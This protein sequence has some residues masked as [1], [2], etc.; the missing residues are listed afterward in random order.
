[1]TSL[2]RW[3]RAAAPSG[4]AVARRRPEIVALSAEMPGID[5]L[6][7]FMRDAELRFE[8]LWM[9]IEERTFG[10]QGEQLTVSETA[11]RHPRLARVTTSEPAAGATG[12]FETWISDGESVRTYSRQHK[13][14]TER[15]V[16]PSVRGLDD[17]D[18]PG[19][20]KI[21][22]PLTALPMETLPETFIH[23]AGY[24]QN[25]LTT[26]RTWISGTEVVRGRETI[27]VQCD[28]PRAT[29][30]AADRP[31]FHIEIAVDRADGAILRLVE[32]IGGDVTRQA[33]AVA[34]EPDAALPPATF[35]FHFPAGTTMLY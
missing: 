17:P 33:V 22:R 5:E 13:L 12:S 1:M 9:R 30:L 8:S 27:V 31:D 28:H 3:D 19:H 10:T 24:C 6:F 32:T 20:T 23:P 29:E 15:P 2:Q 21:Y 26:G 18:L 11:L 16:R 34:F 14:G 25:V 35:D 4:L 7:T